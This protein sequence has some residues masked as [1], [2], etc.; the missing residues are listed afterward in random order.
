VDVN[1]FCNLDDLPSRFRGGAL[2]IGNF[3]GVHL[4]HARLVERLLAMAVKV[5]GPA[6]AFTFSPHPAQLLRPH[7][8][9]T[10]LAWIE[11]NALL[12]R[13]LGVDAVVAF[14]T[15]RA[16]LQL[17]ARQFFQQ[18]V[19]DQ[20]DA[21]AMVE[22]SN[23]FFGHDRSG[24]ISVLHEF[25]AK[26]DMSL[27]VVEPIEIDQQVV[28][29]SRIRGLISAGQIDHA[30]VL[31]GRPYR[32][33]GKVVRGEMRGKK[34]GFPTAN[35]ERIDTLLPGEG[36]YA[37]A[38]HAMGNVYP[39]AVSIGGNPTFDV[40]T[41]KIEA[42]LIGYE[43]L[44]YDE[45]IEVDLLVRLRYIEMFDSPHELITQMKS[46]VAVARKTFDQQHQPDV[47]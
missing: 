8:A 41:L 15:D 22:G 35:I 30:N 13:E 11:R 32:I 19:R 46:D 27:E 7:A 25:C 42:H 34:L 10:P 3:D 14:P 29:S 40:E 24:T 38:A 39:A 17:D 16:F 1:L 12:L 18:I 43:G 44:L 45:L 6:V 37:A 47:S 2:S 20:L 9:P 28:S 21:K 31:L 36:I 26:A 4:G 33:R 5:G 23:F